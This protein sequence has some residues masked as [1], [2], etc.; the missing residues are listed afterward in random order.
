MNVALG[1]DADKVSDLLLA[2]AQDDAD[3]LNN[4]VPS[5]FLDA[6]G[7]SA[8]NFVLPSTSPSPA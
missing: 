4:P 1:T 8:L 5:A 7:E 2:I 3:V 6:F